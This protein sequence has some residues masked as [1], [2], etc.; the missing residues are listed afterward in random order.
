MHTESEMMEVGSEGER[1]G[2]RR[3]RGEGERGEGKRES[4]GIST[5]HFYIHPSGEAK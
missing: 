5:I 4:N 3:Q 1:K 2:R